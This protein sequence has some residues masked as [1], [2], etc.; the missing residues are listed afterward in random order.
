MPI[1]RKV[2]AMKGNTSYFTLFKVL[3]VLKLFLLFYAFFLLA[4]C[5]SATSVSFFCKRDDL[6]IFVNGEELGSGLVHYVA[7]R[8]IKT[9]EVECKK[10]GI[11]V[12][13]RNYYIKGYNNTLFDINVIDDNTYS[14]DR[15]IHSK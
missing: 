4:S 11:I 10:N 12:Y 8:G 7:P 15:Q 2:R 13:Q 5:A 14:S 9:A 6:K 1:G 3:R